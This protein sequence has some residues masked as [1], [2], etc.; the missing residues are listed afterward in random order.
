MISNLDV[1]HHCIKSGSTNN[2]DNYRPITVLPIVSKILEKCVYE[3]VITYLEENSLLCRQQFSF[4]KNRSTELAATCFID[5]IHKCMDRGQYTGAVYIDLSK[6]F[7]TIS[8]TSI[9]AKLPRF[10]IN[11]KAREWF[12]NYLFRRHQRVDFKNN[13]SSPQPIFC[14]VPQG[15]I[16]GSLLFLLHFN[17][18]VKTLLHSKIIKYDDDTVLYVSHKNITV[19]EK[20]LNEDFTRFCSWLEDNELIINLK[21]G[22]TELMIFG[23]SIRLSRNK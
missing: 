2:I 16:L 5:D 17:E 8:H 4:R 6:A 21:K 11:G 1:W 22:K 12:T 20:L 19:I 9:L 14:G 18:S 13:L 23:T 3:Q 10:G 7:D 15:S